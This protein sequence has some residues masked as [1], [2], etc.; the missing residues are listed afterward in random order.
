[1]TDR[2][3]EDATAI[4]E[5]DLFAEGPVVVF[6]WRNEPGWPVEY[7]SPNVERLFG[8]SPEELHEADPPY[9]EIVHD[10][11]I[12]RVAREVESYSDET[13]LRFNHEPYRMVTKDDEIRWVLDYTRI[14]RDDDGIIGYLGY[15]V[16]ITERKA[17][18]EY[19]NVLNSTIRSLH[20]ALIDANSRAEIDEHVCGALA[21]LDGFAGTWIGAVDFSSDAIVPVAQSGVPRSYLESVQLSPDADAPALATRVAFDRDADDEHTV[22][23]LDSDPEEAWRTVALECG[24]R[25]VFTVPIRHRELVYSVLT[26]YGND[27]DTFDSRIREI[28]REL[29]TLVGYA[30][31]AVE[32]RNALYGDGSRDLVLDVSI[33]E[34]DPLRSLAD[35]LSTTV[36]VRSVSQRREDEPLLYCLIPDVDS[37]TALEATEDVR[38]IES[39]EPLSDDETPIYGI[40]TA[41]GSLVSRTTALGA[42]LQSM[43]VSSRGC[44]L[45]VS[46]PHERDHRQFVG[47]VRELFGGAE[48][49]AERDSTPPERM[50]WAT[51]LADTLTD[52]QQDVLQ[53]AYH[54][55]YFDEDRKRT[56][57]EI[58]E[59]LGIAQPTFSRHVR[60][61]QRNLLAA[62]WDRPNDG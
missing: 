49:R 30:I 54:A 14:V 19:V 55:G 29:G 20:E 32:R 17:Q 25:S 62:I 11:D 18:I 12:E 42:S 16:D 37:G 10:A 36:E 46:V 61:A 60:A 40:V 34:G 56:G 28:L 35:R 7:V 24:Y 50:P 2:A 4:E 31:T 59:S 53:T 5:R 8:Y 43:R 58:A 52:R 21:E 6:Q 27:P 33:D 39:I 15:V 22:L 38:S 1:M 47:Q 44:E 3:I 13:T 45:V 48:L 23:D 57:K 41:D 26:V 51:L 9:A